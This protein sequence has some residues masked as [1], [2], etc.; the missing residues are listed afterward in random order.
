LNKSLLGEGW[1]FMTLVRMTPFF[2]FKLSNYFFGAAGFRYVDFIC[3][4]VIGTFPLCVTC[5]YA[6]SLV[7]DATG[8]EGRTLWDFP[9]VKNF[10]VL[11]G[12]VAF[13]G[14]ILISWRAGRNYRRRLAALRIKG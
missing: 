2:P 8:F 6:G 13:A 12:V 14:W 7:A 3:G 4:T 1:V 9:F 11:L 10:S 5:V